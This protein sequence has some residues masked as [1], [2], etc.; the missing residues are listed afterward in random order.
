MQSSLASR[1]IEQ[2]KQSAGLT[3]EAQVVLRCVVLSNALEVARQKSV[4][5]LICAI[6]SI[7]GQKETEAQNIRTQFRGKRL[8]NYC[9]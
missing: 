6:G 1:T 3:M 7:E 5:E 2:E 8:Y 4:A 9:F